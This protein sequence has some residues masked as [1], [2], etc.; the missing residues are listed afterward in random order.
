VVQPRVNLGLAQKPLHALGVFLQIS[1]H[2]MEPVRYA[3]GSGFFRLLTLPHAAG[4]NV[5]SRSLGAFSQ[6]IKNPVAWLKTWAVSDFARST[7]I[8]LYMRTLDST[9]ELTLA[10]TAFTGFRR[11]LESRLTRGAQAP[12]PFMSEATD[13]AR[14]F[15]DKVGGV[16]S[17]LFSETLL[18]TPTTAHILGGACMGSD[19]DSGVI[20]A[21]HRIFGYTWALRHRWQLR[22]CKSGSE[23]ISHHHR[24]G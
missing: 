22:E 9:L 10:R 17:T 4:K 15:A 14:R 11:G 24:I 16:V 12:T 7:Q 23:P 1:R 18:G 2:H 5:V 19:A 6:V 8:L 3:E 20:D 21:R 13:L